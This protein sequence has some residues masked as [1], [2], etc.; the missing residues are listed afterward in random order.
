MSLTK[1]TDFL[2]AGQCI[3]PT[4]LVAPELFSPTL[5]S[6]CLSKLTPPLLHQELQGV[7]AAFTP[8]PSTSACQ[9][10]RLQ[11]PLAPSICWARLGQLLRQPQATA[12]ALLSL[13][14]RYWTSPEQ[15]WG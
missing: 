4:Q 3:P 1:L 12:L 8:H 10:R 15:P 9:K 6:T 14:P 5:R 2:M 13:A 11:L 7:L